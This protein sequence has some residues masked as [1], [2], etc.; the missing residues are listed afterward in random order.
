MIAI[1]SLNDLD[2]PIDPRINSDREPLTGHI[3]PD[4]SGPPLSRGYLN[5]SIGGED[6]RANLNTLDE[7]VWQTVSRDLWAVWEKMRLV[8]WPKHLLG[9]A[10]QRTSAL[11]A[12]ER[13]ESESLAGNM[14]SLMA[15]GVN[16]DMV[17]QGTMSEGLR[18]WDLWL[19]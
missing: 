13:G 14:R 1:A 2:D 5:E 6:R 10:L 16:P 9:G 18:N 8:L 19:V 12:E 17:L 11:S 3:R 15:Q 7:S 4:S